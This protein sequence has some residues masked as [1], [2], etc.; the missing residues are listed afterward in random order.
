VI[1]KPLAGVFFDAGNTLLVEEPGKHL[2]EMAIT[3]IPD[4]FEVLTALKPRYRLGVISNTVG[5]GDAE[6]KEALERAGIWELIDA[7][8]T[9]RDFGKAK[10]DPAIYPEGARRLRVPLDETVMVGD[11]LDTDIAGANRA[12]MDSLLVLTGV[13]TAADLLDAPP[14]HRPTHVGADL[15][16]LFTADGG[17]EGWQVRRRDGRMELGGAGTPVGALRALCAAAWADRAPTAVVPAS[18]DAEAALR[19]L[20]L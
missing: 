6:L 2:W 9:S 12:G 17:P 1:R 16:A 15:D 18:A 5:S 3:P 8:V 20:G 10:P 14:E 11:R 13:S 7:M 4:A 19:T